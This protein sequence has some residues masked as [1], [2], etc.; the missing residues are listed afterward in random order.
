[1]RDDA[2]RHFESWDGAAFQRSL[3]ADAACTF[4]AV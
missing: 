3:T 4:V 1:V 2:A